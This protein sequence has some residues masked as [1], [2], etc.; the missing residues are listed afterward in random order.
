MVKGGDDQCQAQIKLDF[1]DEEILLDRS[2]IC[3]VFYFNGP[4]S[5]D[6]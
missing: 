5:K 3:I 1:L 2:W 4:A 6:I